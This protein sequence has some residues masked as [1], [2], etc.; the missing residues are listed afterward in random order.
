[1][2]DFAKLRRRPV[3]DS[4]EAH[5]EDDR[6]QVSE[7]LH[8][9]YRPKTLKDVIGQDHAVTSLKKVL[10]S[11]TPAH[12]YLFTGPAGVG[13]TTL[14]RIIANRFKCEPA[15]ILE[16]DA[17]TNNGIDAMRDVTAAL[18]YHGFGA[19]PNR[20]IIID[21]CHA[22][23]KAAWQSLLKSVEEPP[24]HV[25][26]FFCT[27]ESGKVPETILT[28][29]HAYTLKSLRYEDALDLVEFVDEEEDL[30]TPKDVMSLV[31][32]ACGGSAR[33]ALVMLSMV[34]GCENADE[35]GPVLETPM[36]NKDVID[37]C[38]GLVSGKLTWVAAV[39]TLKRIPDMNPESV[40]IVVVNY[41]AACLKGAKT[42]RDVA[43]LLDILTP[44]STPFNASDKD[45]P[46]LLA[47]GN[48]I[49]PPN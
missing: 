14:A 7:P 24:A 27:T 2:V 15:S 37:L 38:R 12:A 34:Q 19:S 33:Q 36:E 31:A 41:L 44:F 35:A 23:S 48:L 45:A 5:P 22:L 17:A 43:R 3:T 28:R 10:D 47:L 11:K 42:E 16:I 32:R 8:I 20:A 39:D 21:E 46:L 40:R 25:Y 49:Y 30:G 6:P 1:M 4:A 9:K 18:R 26:F 13:K 29:C